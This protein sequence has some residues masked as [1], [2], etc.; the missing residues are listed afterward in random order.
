[1][2]HDGEFNG[3]EMS[4]LTEP[5]AATPRH[6]L[7]DHRKSA[8]KADNVTALPS[9]QESL[10]KEILRKEMCQHFPAGSVVFKEGDIGDCAYLI[11]K[12]KVEISVKRGDDRVVLAHR[13]PTEVF[14]EIAIIDSMPRSATAIAV[15]PTSLIVIT[16]EQLMRRIEETDPVA[17][18]CLKLV[19]ERFRATMLRLQVL[20]HEDPISVKLKDPEESVFPSGLTSIALRELELERDL[21]EALRRNEFELH[22][23]PIVHLESNKLAGFESLIRWRHPDRSLVPPDS[24][25][26]TAETSGLIV[27]IGRWVLRQALRSAQRLLDCAKPGVLFNDHLSLSINLSPRDLIQPDFIDHLKNALQ[28]ADVAPD[29]L[30][31]EITESLL[32]DEPE[33]TAAI[34]KACKSIGLGISID[35]FGTGF[36]SLS[37]LHRFPIDTLK[38]DRSF[39][40]Q[41]HSCNESMQI[42]KSIINL[43]RQLDIHVVAE[44]VETPDQARTLNELGVELV[45]GFFYGRPADEKLAKKLM[46]SG[47]TPYTHSD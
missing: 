29:V 9:T 18:L 47:L 6:S 12:G 40:K 33:Q 3:D 4:R 24:F 22:F 31:I 46:R 28:L 41:M 17:R 27:P 16:R 45:Q 14:G 10:S 38:I 8:Q 26:P 19:L 23:Q 13:R 2:D 7:T 34:L 37:Y 15:Q 11:N 36:S 43:S 39:I 30:R 21:E 35:D 44:G 25:L 20:D 32:I 5:V 42:I 1:M